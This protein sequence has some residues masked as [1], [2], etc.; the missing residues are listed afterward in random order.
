MLILIPNTANAQAVAEESI[1][2]QYSKIGSVDCHLRR[3]H[4][5][6]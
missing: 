2:S 1:N 5:G 4:G 6:L 3:C